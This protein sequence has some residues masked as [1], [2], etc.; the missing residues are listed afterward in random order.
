MTWLQ[1]SNPDGHL[2]YTVCNC[3]QKCIMSKRKKNTVNSVIMCNHTHT[4][5]KLLK[6]DLIIFDLMI[7]WQ[8][9]A[10]W[11]RTLGCTEKYLIIYY[12]NFPPAKKERQK[13]PTQ[14]CKDKR[15][16]HPSTNCIFAL[17]VQTT[18]LFT[19]IEKAPFKDVLF[20][21]WLYKC[22]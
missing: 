21:I 2:L 3:T 10:V 13:N 18:R 12:T 17:Q 14:T 11:L 19:F 4:H 6:S 15:H 8:H 16:I 5:N 1:F 7:T 9:P 20:L 22:L